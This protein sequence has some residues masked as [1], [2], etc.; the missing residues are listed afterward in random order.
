MSIQGWKRTISMVTWDLNSW[1]VGFS[2]CVLKA[3]AR[4]GM[5]IY[6]GFSTAKLGLYSG[7]CCYHHAGREAVG[8][9][10]WQPSLVRL[11]GQ[12]GPYLY[13]INGWGCLSANV[14]HFNLVYT[15]G[16]SCFNNLSSTAQLWLFI[17]AEKPWW[18]P[19]SPAP[20]V[21]HW[22][23]GPFPSRDLNG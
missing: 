5:L 7:C 6:G 10:Q 18:V 2:N 3:V 22:L 12:W 14:H 9:W 11:W 15:I 23:A 17:V 4:A 20:P 1:N 16:I 19:P 21:Y 8:Q 13:W